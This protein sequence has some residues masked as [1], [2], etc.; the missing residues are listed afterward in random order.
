LTPVLKHVTS[1]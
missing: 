1:L